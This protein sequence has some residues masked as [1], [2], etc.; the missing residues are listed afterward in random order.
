MISSPSSHLRTVTDQLPFPVS[1]T[2]AANQAFQRW[3][4][5]G[6][7]DAE[8]IVDMWTYC[9]VCQYFLSKSTRG[10]FDEAAAPDELIT[11]T[12]DKIRDNRENVQ[13]PEQ[14][15]QWVSVI[16]KN[17][18][19]NYARRN[20]HSDSINEEWGPTP[21]A[22]N[23]HPTAKLGFVQETFEKAIGRLPSYLQQ[24][25]R[26][27]FLGNKDFEEISEVIGKAVPTVRT[28][29]HKALKELRKDDTLQAYIDRS[30][31]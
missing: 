25:A 3:R 5:K 18:F 6:T 4:V 11:R 28:Y 22:E 7:A 23:A 17:T 15:A 31:I 2:R 9:Y 8:R 1:D 13:N 10:A 27:Y 26:L 14:Y 20:R 12:Y 16:C 19:L 29:K 24:T 30:N 21:R